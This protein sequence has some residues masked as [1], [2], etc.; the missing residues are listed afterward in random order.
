M[1]ESQESWGATFIDRGEEDTDRST[2]GEEQPHIPEP[3]MCDDG[4][5][6][7][8]KTWAN[9]APAEMWLGVADGLM[10]TAFATR[11]AT[12]VYVHAVD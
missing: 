8:T 10:G 2:D 3:G 6:A 12:T 4:L 9:R 11:T 5:E 1:W 7:A